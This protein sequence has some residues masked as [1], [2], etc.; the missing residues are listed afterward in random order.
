M[1]SIRT[2]H[3]ASQ[4]L[5]LLGVVTFNPQALAIDPNRQA[6]IEIESDQAELD[7]TNGTA[8]YSGHVIIKQGMSRLEADSVS[9]TA[10][11]GR[12]ES[13]DASGNPARF[14][15]LN[16]AQNQTV[17]DIRGESE[18]IHYQSE[19]AT[20]TFQGQARLEQ[21]QNSFSGDTIIYDIE[22]RA[23]KASGDQSGETR[24][25]IQYQPKAEAG[26]IKPTTPETSDA[27][28]EAT[29]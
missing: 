7:E 2:I 16:G 24:V 12:L 1:L 17:R 18:R 14:V 20:L 13:I 8:I 27:N 22:A 21:D 6:A 9:V 15:D 28:A 23:I 5:A 26:D 4:L 29:Q 10:T 19:T 11:N 3:K 25:R